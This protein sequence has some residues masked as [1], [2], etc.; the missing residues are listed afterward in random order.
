MGMFFDH[1]SHECQGWRWLVIMS[2]TF[3]SKKKAGKFM[4]AQTATKVFILGLSY[5]DVLPFCAELE[6]GG[7][8]W[9]KAFCS[10]LLLITLTAHSSC[11]SNPKFFRILLGR[12]AFTSLSTLSEICF[13]WWF[14]LA[15]SNCTCL[16]FSRNSFKFLCTDDNLFW[17]PSLF[18]SILFHTYFLLLR[19]NFWR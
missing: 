8:R 11:E 7:K 12:M 16:L 19:W 3:D 6:V 1:A 10:A 5:T 9:G 13:T 2:S 4:T 15:Q 17:F 18:Y 14:L